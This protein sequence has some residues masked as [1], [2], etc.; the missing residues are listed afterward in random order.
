MSNNGSLLEEHGQ[1][2][3]SPVRAWTWFSRANLVKQFTVDGHRYGLI[4]DDL[5]IYLPPHE[6]RF[7]DGVLELLL[8]QLKY[9]YESGASRVDA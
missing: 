3:L 9:M 6:Q 2:L 5:V 7:K 8:T 1:G 4:W